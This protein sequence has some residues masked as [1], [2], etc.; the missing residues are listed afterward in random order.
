MSAVSLGLQNVFS[1]ASRE[2]CMTNLKKIRLPLIN[3]RGVQP[4]ATAAVLVPLCSINE[5]PSLL[6]TVRSAYLKSNSG[7]ISFPGGKTDNNETPTE[8]AMRETREEIGLLPKKINIWGCGPTLPGKNYKIM[9]TPVVGCITDL[10][11]NDLTLNKNEVSEVF[12]VPLEELCNSKNQYHTQF[13][14]GF[15]LP[16]FV[17][18]E[19]KIWG[20]TAY[21]THIVLSCLLPTDVYRNEWMKRKIDI[22][23]VN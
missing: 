2:R 9:I 7:Q 1:L 21:I 5:V 23:H 14:N 3:K 8:T 15:I 6:Y 20:I 10:R 22:K 18:D 4:S 13:S 11:E 12:A 16:V 17:A 19:F